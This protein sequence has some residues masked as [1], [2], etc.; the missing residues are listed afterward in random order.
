MSEKSG[1]KWCYVGE[2]IITYVCTY[3]GRQVREYFVHIQLISMSKLWRT[4]NRVGMQ[5]DLVLP[6]EAWKSFPKFLSL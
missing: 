5:K 4:Y 3:L 6:S 1:E 2:F